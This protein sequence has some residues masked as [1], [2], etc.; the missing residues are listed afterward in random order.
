MKNDDFLEGQNIKNELGLNHASIPESASKKLFNSIVRIEKGQIFATG[1]F[2]KFKIKEIFLHCLLTNH[3]VITQEDVNSNKGINIYFGEKQNEKE[4]YIILDKK[5]RFIKC[6]KEPIDITVIAINN[7]DNIPENKFLNPDLNYINGFDNYKNKDFYLAGYPKSK[8]YKKERHC[9]SGKIVSVNNYIFTHSL[10][11]NEGSSG[12]PICFIENPLVIGIHRG[13][14]ETKKINIGTFIGYIVDELNKEDISHYYYNSKLQNKNT[15]KNKYFFTLE[16]YIDKICN[17]HKIISKYYNNLTENYFYEA[18]IDVNHYLLN[19]NSNINL[20]KK[21]EDFLSEL[22]D[23][24]NINVNYKKIIFA[25]EILEDINSLLH[26]NFEKT[27]EIFGYFIAG[28]MYAL[29][30]CGNTL[31]CELKIDSLLYNKIEMDLSD[32]KLFQQNINEIISFKTFLC[33]LTT[34]EH[35]HGQIYRLFKDSNSFFKKIYSELVENKKYTVSIKINYQYNPKWKTN[36]FSVSKTTIS[37]PA[38]I[39]Q[40]FSFFRIKNV[41]I[42]ENNFEGEILLDSIPRKEILEEKLYNE[43]DTNF[44]SYNINENIFEILN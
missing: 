40:F 25:S 23:F 16:E 1:F 18:F 2:I 22:E 33:D 9:S 31:Y 5:E 30:K 7:K 8:N 4:R 35:L 34:L 13:G 21:R 6:F 44:I 26:S 14:I 3:H 42:N 28:I 41:I 12:S 37:L 15:E 39:F 43:F 38:K 17:F 20:N 32:L 29:D 36:C 27:L 24:N 19:S 10:D 11:T